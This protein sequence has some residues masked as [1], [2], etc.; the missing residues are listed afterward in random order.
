MVARMTVKIE[1]DLKKEIQAEAK[2]RGIDMSA[3]VR[4]TLTDALEATRERR[5]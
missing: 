4:L 3:W 1:P 2:R 5:Q